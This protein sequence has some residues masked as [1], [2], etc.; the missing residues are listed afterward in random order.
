MREIKLSHHQQTH[1]HMWQH[2][3]DQLMYGFLRHCVS[4]T[5][6]NCN[7][8]SLIR[9][10]FC[11]WL[12]QLRWELR[13]SVLRAPV[14]KRLGKLHVVTTTIYFSNAMTM[15]AIYLFTCA[16]FP[17]VDCHT[18]SEWSR[19][20]VITCSESAVITKQV[21]SSV[22]ETWYFSSSRVNDHILMLL[23]PL[24]LI[25]NVHTCN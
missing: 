7:L 2:L 1:E 18:L 17:P 6:L 9:R 5:R 21:I 25:W 13:Q 16:N 20:P 19:E 22:C 3:S 8:L 15:L 4:P 11:L 14:E 24:E 10:D 23:S 12:R